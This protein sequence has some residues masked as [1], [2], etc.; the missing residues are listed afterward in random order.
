[1]RLW[2]ESPPAAAWVGFYGAGLGENAAPTSYRAD[3]ALYVIFGDQH[4]EFLMAS[5]VR[6]K[7]VGAALD[8]FHALGFNACGVQEIVDKAGVPKGSFYNYFKSKELLALEVVE[9][10]TQ[11]MGREILS[12]KSLA[13]LQRL[14]KHFEFLAARR[15]KLGYDKGCL[16]CNLAAESSKDVPLVREAVAESLAAWTAL[17][18]ATIRDGQAD[19]SIGPELDAEQV[20]R[21]LLNGWRG[22]AVR[23]KLMNSGQ[24]LNDFFKVAFPLLESSNHG[25]KA[26]VKPACRRAASRH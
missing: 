9:I 7:I 22:A 16:M 24:P 12:D 23:M 26:G 21:F 5:K 3:C 11:G 18:A 15:A 14:R 10:Y 19:D 6:A 20:A 8:R 17:I 13:P 2:V 4:G 1:M 25:A